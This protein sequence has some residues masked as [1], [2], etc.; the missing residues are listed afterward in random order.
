M[1]EISFF[2]TMCASTF[3][4][5]P[6]QLEAKKEKCLISLYISTIPQNDLDCMQLP[7]TIR[8]RIQASMPILVPS[9]RCSISCQPPSVSSAT[10]GLLQP[11]FSFPTSHPG[12]TNQSQRNSGSLVRPGKLKN[13]PLQ[14]DSDVEIDPWTLLEDGA[15]AGLSS[16][17]T[18]VIG[19][20]DHANLRASSWLRGTVRVR[21][22]D[23]TYIGAVDDDS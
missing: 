10:L 11:T 3:L 19:S 17:N 20:G 12:N 6:L 23:L 14:Q 8:W 15:G 16:G 1:V 5:Q 4:L 22:T 7:D 13:T 18:A 2:N 9:G 21:R